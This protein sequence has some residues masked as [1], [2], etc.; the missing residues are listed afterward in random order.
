MMRMLCAFVRFP[1]DEPDDE[2]L[3]DEGPCSR[4]LRP[5]VQAAVEVIGS[6]TERHVKLESRLATDPTFANQ[7]SSGWSFTMETSQRST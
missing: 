4:T 6:R 2:I 1:P 7:T 3:S 5:D